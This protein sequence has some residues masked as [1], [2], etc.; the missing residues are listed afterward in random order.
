MVF[1]LLNSLELK[2]VG[3][4]RSHS[5][6]DVALKV[7]TCECHPLTSIA[8]RQNMLRRFIHNP[9]FFPFDLNRQES[10][11]SHVCENG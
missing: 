2:T 1:K 9:S 11:E 6:G 8:F 3:A 7:L 4:L 10:L 5:V